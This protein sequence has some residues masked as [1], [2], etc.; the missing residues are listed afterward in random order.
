MKIQWIKQYQTLF[1][2]EFA[3]GV[4]KTAGGISYR[5]RD[6]RHEASSLIARREFLTEC[7]SSSFQ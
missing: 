2:D 6:S 4:W 5:K 7:F 3:L 1:H